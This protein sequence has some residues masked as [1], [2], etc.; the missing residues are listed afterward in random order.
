MRLRPYVLNDRKRE[1]I[2]KA[3]KTCTLAIHYTI[4]SHF[5]KFYSTEKDFMQ[6]SSF[7]WGRATALLY[8]QV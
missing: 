3:M 4:S 5:I 6:I 2:E 8:T 7:M 1:Y